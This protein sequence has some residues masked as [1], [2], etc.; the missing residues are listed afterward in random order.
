[1]FTDTM[2]IYYPVKTIG[3]SKQ[4]D[5]SSEN[6]L[7]QHFWQL[8]KVDPDLRWRIPPQTLDGRLPWVDLGL[9]EH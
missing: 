8:T 9:D 4:V 6:E 1:M 3:F 7:V 2:V 5:I